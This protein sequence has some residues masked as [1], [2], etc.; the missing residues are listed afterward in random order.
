MI[1]EKKSNISQDFEKQY[2]IFLY[3]FLIKNY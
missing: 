1:L 2:F 3:F